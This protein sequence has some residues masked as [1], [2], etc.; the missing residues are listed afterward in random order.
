VN[1]PPVEPPI[2]FPSSRTS[3]EDKDAD[4]DLGRDLEGEGETLPEYNDGTEP[5]VVEVDTNAKKGAEG[6]EAEHIHIHH[7]D[8]L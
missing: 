4:K 6:G 5:A 1:W 7:G 2:A 3:E 8:E